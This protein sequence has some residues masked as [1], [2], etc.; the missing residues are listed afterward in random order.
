M[1]AKQ[2]KIAITLPPEYSEREKTAIAQDIIDYI[3]K[4]TEEGKDKNNRNFK[5]YSTGYAKS[6]DFKNAG[7]SKGDVNLKL[8]G[9]MLAALK[10]LDIKRDK[11]IVGYDAGTPENGKAE[12]NILGT[13]GQKKSTGKARDFLGITSKALRDEILRRYPLS[14]PEKL[15]KRT[16]SVIQSGDAAQ[17]IIDEQS[18]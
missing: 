16:E 6:L 15:A 11:V 8:S 14:D 9:D 18:D 1:A 17:E 7:K 13:Y 12:G 4:R 3:V 10:I 5:G 2:Q